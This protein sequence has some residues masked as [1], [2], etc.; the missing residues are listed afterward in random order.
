MDIEEVHFAGSPLDQ[1]LQEVGCDLRCTIEAPKAKMTD[2]SPEVPRAKRNASAEGGR[3][4]AKEIAMLCE[5]CCLLS[6][7]AITASG[8]SKGGAK[9]WPWS[10]PVNL[11]MGFTFLTLWRRGGGWGGLWGTS[12]AA[13]LAASCWQSFKLFARALVMWEA[14]RAC[15]ALQWLFNEAEASVQF[16]RSLEI[17]ADIVEGGLALS[18]IAANFYAA[19]EAEAGQLCRRLSLGAAAP[20]PGAHAG[21]ARLRVAFARVWELQ[22][23]LLLVALRSCVAGKLRDAWSELWALRKMAQ[24]TARCLSRHLAYAESC[25]ATRGKQGGGASGGASEPGGL[26][27]RVSLSLAL[28]TFSQ[29]M[30]RRKEVLHSPE[31]YHAWLQDLIGRL[32]AHLDD[33]SK[34]NPEKILQDP[35][36]KEF[37]EEVCP[38]NTKISQGQLLEA[39]GYTVLH[40]ALGKRAPEHHLPGRSSALSQE[41]ELQLRRDSQTAWRSC[42]E[43]L[44]GKLDK[45]S[46]AARLWQ[47]RQECASRIARVCEDDELQAW[48]DLP[49]A[50]QGATRQGR[51]RPSQAQQ[52]LMQALSV[53]LDGRTQS[54]DVLE[55]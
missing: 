35:E 15:K 51:W 52:E 34:V 41:E 50:E 48:G 5:S 46:G 40:E 9:Y 31:A 1:Y 26:G 2:D 19:A 32:E 12:G 6:T 43:E 47:H 53:K 23:A 44:Q 24:D 13:C 7:D 29:A 27:A 18:S 11:S 22:E 30:K 10:L 28:A 17:E 45:K 55:T 54:S 3:Q 33:L 21:A 4:L 20:P 14:R 42:V 39:A 8:L 37:S 49:A 16:L 36:D 38:P 25:K